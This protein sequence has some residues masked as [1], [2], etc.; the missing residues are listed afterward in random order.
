MEIVIVAGLQ[1]G[2]FFVILFL[3]KKDEGV[4]LSLKMVV[5]WI[6]G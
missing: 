6:K 4:S 5:I 1:W 3:K 2:Y